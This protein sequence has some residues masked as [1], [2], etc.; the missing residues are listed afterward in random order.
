M[1]QKELSVNFFGFSDYSVQVQP[2]PQ[3]NT[4]LA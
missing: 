2:T 4:A 1:T 3:A